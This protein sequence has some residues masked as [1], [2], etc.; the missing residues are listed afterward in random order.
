MTPTLTVDHIA[1]R[2][3]SLSASVPWY[4]RYFAGHRTW[5]LTE[6]SDLTRT[7][8]PGISTLVEVVAGDLTFHL[9]EQEDSAAAGTGGCGAV[10]HLGIHVD[11]VGEV[12]E[13]HDRWLELS[14]DTNTAPGGSVTELTED[15]LNETVSFYCTDPDGT[16]FEIIAPGVLPDKR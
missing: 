1:I 5:T 2:V 10:Q 4:V 16:E 15:R 14:L 7:R 3:S 8:L 9:F 6:F 13:L 11:S 12:R